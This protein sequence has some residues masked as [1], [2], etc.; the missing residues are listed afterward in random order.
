MTD[1]DT[2]VSIDMTDWFE[3]DTP[4]TCDEWALVQALASYQHVRNA[5][6]GVWEFVLNPAHVQGSLRAGAPLIDRI[7]S[8]CRPDFVD[9]LREHAAAGR[10]ILVHQGT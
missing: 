10:Y 8:Q 3:Y 5:E 9:L 7:V 2:L 4:D 6:D 1:M